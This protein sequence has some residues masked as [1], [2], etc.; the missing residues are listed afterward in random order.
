MTGLPDPKRHLAF[1]G[2]VG[3]GPRLAAFALF[4]EGRDL[5]G[6]RH[7]LGAIL[8][9]SLLLCRS[10]A[11]PLFLV[12]ETGNMPL[13]RQPADGAAGSLLSRGRRRRR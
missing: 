10:Q 6:Q 1:A 3:Q 11:P 12:L 7:A 2:L 5:V 4:D 13:G 9:F 8:G